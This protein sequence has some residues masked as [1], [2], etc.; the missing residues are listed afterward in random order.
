M[1]EDLTEI[2][3]LYN[4][5]KAKQDLSAGP[6]NVSSYSELIQQIDEELSKTQYY[7]DFKNK[8]K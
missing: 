2:P 8:H 1:K 6:I 4:T 5:N 7:N 3:S